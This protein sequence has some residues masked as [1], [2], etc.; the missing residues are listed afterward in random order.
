MTFNPTFLALC[1]FPHSEAIHAG[2][3]WDYQ[4]KTIDINCS[5]NLLVA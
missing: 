5:D 3:H 1:I 4:H 2:L